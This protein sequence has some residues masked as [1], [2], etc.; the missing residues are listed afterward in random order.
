MKFFYAMANGRICNNGIGVVEDEGKTI[1][2]EEDKRDYFY[3]KFKELFAPNE[4]ERL[5]T[6]DWSG[7]FMDKPLLK[8]NHLTRPFSLEEVRNAT[9]L[10]GGDKA[11]GPDGFNMQFF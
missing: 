8:H 1:Y 6:G 7:L 2:K 4:S 5:L 9:F 10:L 3:L 11:P